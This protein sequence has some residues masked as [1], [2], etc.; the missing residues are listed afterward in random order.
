MDG[1]TLLSCLQL[2]EDIHHPCLWDHHGDCHTKRGGN[3]NRLHV[4][5]ITPFN[6]PAFIYSV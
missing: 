3:T 1:K 2:S 4:L 6:E 5:K